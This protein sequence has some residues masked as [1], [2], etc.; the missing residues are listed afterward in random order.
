MYGQIQEYFFSNGLMSKYQHAYRKGY[1]TSTALTQMTDNWLKD[2]DDSKAVAVV[3]LDLSAAF[4]VIDHDILIK[5]LTCYGFTPSATIMI[6]S[7]LTARTQRVYYNG[8]MSN[9]INLACGVP[10]GS[11]LGPLLFSIFTND[12]PS[13]VKNSSIVMHADDSTM[14]YGAKTF[15]ELNEVLSK[16][17]DI[18]HKWMLRNKLV[19]NITKTQ[20]IIL[21]TKQKVATMPNLDL[22][23]ANELIQQVDKIKLLGLVID[24]H[25][26]WSEHINKI[27]SKM[28]VGIHDKAVHTL[29]SI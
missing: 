10:Q 27:I 13:V 8:S 11:C 5:K 17:L 15:H 4:D 6:M 1:S 20:S 19:L 18:V 23:I 26:P 2:V 12:L 14:Y 7:Y 9:S 16:E 21:G 29:C 22:H 28:R 24:S 25:L 3:T